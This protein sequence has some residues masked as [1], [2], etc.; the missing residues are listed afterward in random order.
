MFRFVDCACAPLA[1]DRGDGVQVLGMQWMP[2]G[3][4]FTYDISSIKCIPQNVVSCL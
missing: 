4:F 2:D 3:D 1:F